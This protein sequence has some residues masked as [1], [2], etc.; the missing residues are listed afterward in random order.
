MRRVLRIIR[1]ILLLAIAA[2]VVLAGVL[3]FN[4]VTPRLAAAS[5]RGRAA[6]R[7]R[8]HRRA[9]KRGWRRRSA[10][11]PFRASTIPTRTPRRCAACARISKR[12]SRRFMPRRNARSSV[13]YSLLYTWARLRPEGAA[14]RACWRIRTW[15]RWRRAPRR[16]GSSRPLTASSPTASSGA[17]APGTT[18]ATSIRCW[19]PPRRWPRPSFRPKR[20]IY[21]AFGHDEEVAGTR[22]AKAIAAT[23]ASRGIRLDFVIDEGL[24]ITDGIMKGLD[25]PAALI[26][27]AE[28][29]YATLVLN[30]Q[31]DA[32][33]FL[34]A[35]ARYRDRHDERGA[36]AAGRSSPADADPRLRSRRCSTRWRRRCRGFNRV[37]LSNLWPQER[38][39]MA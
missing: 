22:G 5:G 31:A 26:G 4:V 38:S 35:A 3:A 23:L 25:K 18:R 39:V 17:A 14:D 27:V 9:A 12:A 2:I 13:G 29:G 34:D 1:N 24:L 30:A 33:P 8:Q 7:G 32:R 6:R 16:T 19:R 11:A 15:C 10:S 21:F 28:K 37:V 36:G 20:T